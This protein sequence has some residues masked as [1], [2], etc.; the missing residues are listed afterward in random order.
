MQAKSKGFLL[1]VGALALS[2]A[3]ALTAGPAA[4]KDVSSATKVQAGPVARADGRSEPVRYG[5]LDLAQTSD[6]RILLGRITV[7]AKRVCGPDPTLETSDLSIKVPQTRAYRE[8]VQDAVESAVNDINNPVVTEIYRGG[9]QT[10][11][12]ATA[13]SNLTD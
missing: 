10:A 9:S 4:A 7:A 3:A 1:L 12:A 2:G 13:R 5:D 6:A 8:C 11:V